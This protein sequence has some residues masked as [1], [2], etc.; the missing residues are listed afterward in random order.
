MTPAPVDIIAFRRCPSMAGRQR[1]D[2]QRAG[3][4]RHGL[5][6]LAE[7]RAVAFADQAAPARRDGDILLAARGVADDAAGMADAVV[8]RPQLLSGLGVIRVRDAR[9]VRQEHEVAGGGQHARQRR[10]RELTP[11]T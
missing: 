7:Q 4:H 8:V 6:R 1:V 10:L 11:A 9:R 2:D 3:I 5:A